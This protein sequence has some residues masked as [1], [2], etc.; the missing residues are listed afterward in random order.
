MIVLGGFFEHFF[1]INRFFKSNE[2]LHIKSSG[3]LQ[4]KVDK[5]T[6]FALTNSQV[7]I[8]FLSKKLK[9]VIFWLVNKSNAML[10]VK[11]S[12]LQNRLSFYLTWAALG[13]C[14]D[15]N[16][17]FDKHSFYKYANPFL[18]IISVLNTVKTPKN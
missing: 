6:N 10:T 8:D 11:R 18:A 7:I 4:K 5:I 15:G 2:I 13:Y 17:I 1:F 16:T 3:N 9:F 12:E 14:I